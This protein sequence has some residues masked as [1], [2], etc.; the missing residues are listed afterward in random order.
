M[1]KN[2]ASF[3]LTRAH[4]K[5]AAQISLYQ[6]GVAETEA[7]MQE[8]IAG[9]G[10]VSAQALRHQMAVQKMGLAEARIYESELIQDMKEA[11]KARKNQLNLSSGLGAD[12]YGNGDK[13]DMAA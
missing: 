4:G 11:L 12:G 7:A 13:L 2:I 6:Q 10:N 8:H 3:N 5:T 1:Q 9:G